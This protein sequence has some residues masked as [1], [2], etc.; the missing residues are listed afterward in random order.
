MQITSAKFLPGLK[1]LLLPNTGGGKKGKAELRLSGSK[2]CGG[3]DFRKHRSYLNAHF[4][5][6]DFGKVDLF[7][8]GCLG[9]GVRF[10]SYAAFIKN[11]TRKNYSIF[12][13][14]T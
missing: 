4:P 3:I 13:L 11:S 12:E 6:F 5:D 8:G 10:F 2:L 7:L 14:G 9:A 1:T